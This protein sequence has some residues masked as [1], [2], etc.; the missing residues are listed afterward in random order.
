MLD[1]DEFDIKE[2]TSIRVASE[3]ERALKA[4]DEEPLSYL[5]V[6]AQTNSLTQATKEDGKLGKLKAFWMGQGVHHEK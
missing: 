6:Q 4:S 3:G 5:C 2:G 1:N